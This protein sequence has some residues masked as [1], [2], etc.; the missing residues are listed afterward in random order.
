MKAYLLLLSGEKKYDVFEAEENIGI[1][2]LYQITSSYPSYR[3]QYISDISKGYECYSELHEVDMKD[4]DKDEFRTA[5]NVLIE[6]LIETRNHKN[7]HIR[8]SD[9]WTPELDYDFHDET[10]YIVQENDDNEF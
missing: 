6:H 1:D 10:Y 4:M 9:E 5:T 3:I 8:Y 2:E 7:I